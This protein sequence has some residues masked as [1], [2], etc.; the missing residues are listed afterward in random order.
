MEPTDCVLSAEY[1]KQRYWKFW[2]SKTVRGI[3]VRLM[4][5]RNE[6]GTFTMAL[7]YDINDRGKQ[8]FKKEAK[9]DAEVVAEAE[10]MMK[11]VPIPGMV[12]TLRDF[13]ECDTFE[14]FVQKFEAEGLTVI[15]KKGFP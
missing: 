2:T 5:R 10:Q 13:S 14:K 11:T 9:S 1:P 12:F 4:S 6:D 8:S 7:V 3:N 15:E